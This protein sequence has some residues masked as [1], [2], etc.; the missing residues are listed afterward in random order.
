MT[1]KVIMA[2]F[3]GQGV[4]LMGTLLSYSAMVEGKHTTFFPSYGAEMRGGT[5]N[6]SVVVSDDE[7]ASPVVNRP[8]CIVA[9]NIASLEKFESRVKPGGTIFVNSS[10]IK[11][12]VER[13]DVEEIRIPANDIAEELGNSRAANMV[14]LGGLLKKTGAVKVDAVIGC[15]EKVLSE[16]AMALLDLNKKALR[17]GFEEI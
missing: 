4:V 12:K 5:A 1:T 6:C 7:I 17:R 8:D 13:D 11:R 16:R 3:G 15:L 10:L 9:M 2:G 14:I